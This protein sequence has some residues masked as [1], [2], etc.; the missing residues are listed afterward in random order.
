MSDVGKVSLG[1]VLNSKSLL[2]QMRGMSPQLT[3]MFNGLGKKLGGAL[4]AGLSVKALVGFGKTCI[5]LG[6]D[7]AEVQNVVDVT[8]GSMSGKVD[9][10]AKSAATQF[11]LSETMAKQYTGT[12]GAMAKAYGFTT[13]QA[14]QM[15][16]ALTGLSGDVASFYNLDT[17]EAFTKLKAVFT[18]ET[19]GLKSLGVVMTQTA[20]DQFAMEQGFGKTTSQMTEQEKAALRY[21]FVLDKLNGAA[22]DF[23]RTSG[24]WANQVRILKLQFES[25]QATIGEGLIEALTP[26]I[27]ALN[28]FMG[29]LIRAAQAFRNFIF[30]V[31]GKKASATVAGGSADMSAALGGVADSSAAAAEGLAGAG[32]SASGAAKEIK[33]A[34]A[35][36]DQI[37]KLADSSSS[38]GGSGGGGGAGGAIDDMLGEATSALDEADPE[39]FASKLGEM[40][41][42]AWE[43]ADFSFIGNLIGEKLAGALDS[44]PWD[45]AKTAFAK[46]SKSVATL[47]NGFLEAE[48]LSE[49]VGATIGEAL[50]TAFGTVNTF[51]EEFH[52]DSLG[53][54][55]TEGIQSA[56]NTFNW[57]ELTR[58]ISNRLKAALNLCAGLIDGINWESLP[59][60]IVNA[61]K[62]ALTGAD[63]AGI[64]E[65]IGKFIGSSLKAYYNFSEGIAVMLENLIGSIADYF[66][67]HINDAKA[68]G[69]TV[70]QGI[71]S[72]IGEAFLEIGSWVYENIVDPLMSGLLGENVWADVKD[73]GASIMSNLQEGISNNWTLIKTWF[74]DTFVR[75]IVQFGID[76]ANGLAEPVVNA[77]N[78]VIDT[79]NSAIELLPQ[80]L[81]DRL[82][83]QELENIPVKLIPDLDPPPGT[84]Y[85]ETKAEIEAQSKKNPAS[86]TSTANLAGATDRIPE[87]DKA[88]KGFKAYFNSADRNSDKSVKGIGSVWSYGK[89]WFNKKDQNSDKSVKGI[90]SVWSYGKVWF[91]EKNQNSDKSVKGIGSVWSYGKVWFND[92]KDS[93][94]TEQKTI[95]VTARYTRAEDALS[96]NSGDYKAHALGGA[97]YGGSWHSIPQYARGG[98]PHG[99]MFWA[100]EAGPEVVGHVGGRTEVLNQS[101]LAATMFSSVSS[102]MRY[103]E[104]YTPH[105]AVI[106]SS[107]SRSEQHL[108][109]LA[110][111]A[112]N[113]ASGGS[114]REAL[115]LLREILV[116]L[117]TMKLEASI[118][119]RDVKDIIVQLINE[120]TKANGG[121]CELVV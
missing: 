19:E 113:A 18:G 21:Q 65:A 55:I 102:A 56:F 66:T 79:I 32:S 74:S 46:V 86:V 39:T 16:T 1:L 78:S 73:A 67:Q 62:E 119:G 70:A 87:N 7:L 89:V 93:L 3:G 35:G 30:T 120:D 28:S 108:A 76:A 71:L 117:K 103:R 105:L 13:E 69:G 75:G 53:S 33:R 9:A 91:N 115:S 58:W 12:F 88:V 34:L 106:G 68:S 26:A 47:L 52:W 63:Y 95:N 96:R 57:G 49:S 4:V 8:F 111:Q 48:G 10:F 31:F 38:G 59:G 94:T 112:E 40:F 107:V 36:F 101:Q 118:G 11:G 43:T 50:N 14:Y 54:F 77:F 29:V 24:G 45:K 121:V 51:V 20:L 90:G 5:E 25:L 104:R 110:K 41:H 2:S 116:L 64:V 44:I 100:G 92:A 97:Y 85:N 60:D 61:V 23:S 6:S 114:T 37:T 72:G 109:T 22:G 42:T 99:T 82:G 27:Q 83:I 81:K 80:G 84:F 17:E 15:S 98:R